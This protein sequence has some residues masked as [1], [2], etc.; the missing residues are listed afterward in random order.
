MEPTMLQIVLSGAGA[1]AA[2]VASGVIPDA[3]CR[4]RGHPEKQVSSIRFEDG[5]HGIATACRCDFTRGTTT[6]TCDEHEEDLCPARL[7]DAAPA[8]YRSR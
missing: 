8:R 5:C 7:W 2:L 3:I 6:Y 1:G 4:L